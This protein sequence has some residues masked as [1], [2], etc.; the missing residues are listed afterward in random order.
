MAAEL[1]STSL[2]PAQPSYI[3]RGHTAQIHSVQIVRQNTRLLTGD[4][5]GWIVYWK[6]ESKRPV[7]VWRAHDAAILG[8]AEWGLDKIITH[9]RDNALKVWQ[10]RATDEPNLSTVLP[11]DGS[12]AHRPKPWL[13]HSLPVNTLNFSP[14]SMCHERPA[15]NI[16]GGE[17]IG[18][19]QGHASSTGLSDSILVAVPARDDK[20]IEVYQ[21]P[22]ERLAYIV[23]RVQP[24]DTG[25]V[26]AV[27][28]IHRQYSNNLMVIAGY[29]G[30]F[31]AVHLLDRYSRP[32]PLASTRTIPEFAQ[33]IYLSQPHTQ[34]I[35]SLDAS[36]DAKTYFTSS[37]DAVI[38]AHRIPEPPL[39]IDDTN[40]PSTIGANESPSVAEG[41]PITVIGSPSM[42]LRIAE[43]PLHGS[44]LSSTLPTLIEQA[45]PSS[46]AATSSQDVT[47][48]TQPTPSPAGTSSTEPLTF[49]KQPISSPSAATSPITFSKQPI[50]SSP[51]SYNP[52]TSQSPMPK[53]PSGLS[54]LLST[55]LL[56][57][58][59]KPP[60]RP[61]PITSPQP[62]YKTVQ[63]KHAGQ[64]SLRVRSD[65]RLLVTGGWDSRVRIYS[66]KTLK[67]V[68]VL[69]WH[70]EGVYAAG[71]GEILDNND[72]SPYIE[73]LRK[74]PSQ[75]TAEEE[76][77]SEAGEVAKREYRLSG[78]SK[79][80][81][82]REEKMQM[83]HLVVAGA[84]D[85]KVSL[86]EI[87]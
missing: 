79:L 18:L 11:A 68:A 17:S 33:T 10:I 40:N 44:R 5:D 82:Q 42:N 20:K 84:K 47:S 56:Q 13:L 65:G 36:P 22:S 52:N 67:E 48:P 2:P 78:L 66:A 59:L 74:E 6:L 24:T 3:F 85:G 27:K 53:A 15:V 86:W 64:Q 63:T 1:Q 55:A 12:T 16:P 73:K 35:L 70:K 23:R 62:A 80:Q 58:K 72:S 50:N 26:M 31:T 14:F 49:S 45:T 37:A 75:D 39:N 77:N 69:K 8:T 30:G 32:T 7:A 81:R 54:S 25:M 9:G 51:T 46:S 76:R 41:A 87:Y 71:F 60:Q 43:K 83:K 28:L 19:D 4:A 34:P 61:A 57:P 21:L 29:E 38:A